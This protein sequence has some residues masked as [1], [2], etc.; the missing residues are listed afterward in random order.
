MLLT[1]EQILQGV[2][3][4]NNQF[5]QRM[6]ALKSKGMS[7]DNIQDVVMKAIESLDDSHRSFVIYGD[8][9]SGKTEMMIGLNA[10]LLDLGY[11]MI[12]NLVNDSKDMLAQNLDRFTA[13]RLNPAP[14]THQ[15]VGEIALGRPYVI[16][17]KKNAKNLHTLNSLVSK[18]KGEGLV[19]ID[20]EADHA[21]PNAKVNATDDEERSK[22]N[23]LVHT[24]LRR[25]RTG[26]VPG[27]YIGVTATPARLD[28]NATFGNE[29]ERW[30]YYKPHSGYVGQDFFFPQSIQGKM[31]VAYGLNTFPQNTGNDKEQLC[32][33][34]L[35]FLC[36]V[37]DIN[38]AGGEECNFSM[39][40]HTSRKTKEQEEDEKVLNGIL[41]R[42]S[43][44]Q[45]AKGKALFG[46]LL[47]MARARMPNDEERAQKI[48]RYI[49]GNIARNKVGVINSTTQ[50]EG[51]AGILKPV[52]PFTFAIGGNIVSRGLTFEHLLSMYFTR[53]VKANFQ[54][55]TYIQRARMFGARDK[56]L[57]RHFELWIPTELFR[58]W[59]RCFSYHKLSVEAIKE[60]RGA[61]VWIAGEGVVPTQM[62]AIN[63]AAVNMKGGE[64]SFGLFEFQSEHEQ[65]MTD[66]NAGQ[67]AVMIDKL[68]QAL[69]EECFPN[70]VCAYI[71]SRI[72]AG[73]SVYFH[74]HTVFAVKPG[75][76]YTQEE[77]EKCS[78]KERFFRRESSEQAFRNTPL[79]N[80]RQ[81]H[82]R[83]QGAFVLQVAEWSGEVYQSDR[84]NQTW[85]SPIRNFSSE[86]CSGGLSAM[87]GSL[88]S[89][90][91]RQSIPMW[92]SST[93]IHCILKSQRKEK[94]RG[95]SLSP[96]KVWSASP[97]CERTAA[98][99]SSL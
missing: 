49:A 77:I 81:P 54:Q 11:S 1:A 43:D 20:D 95:N 30:I 98:N 74:R 39:L 33:A 61:P 50:A 86:P 31:E 32:K 58:D 69:G 72:D 59:H 92:C 23:S 28:L 9:Q 17:S 75:H 12:I 78:A 67:P 40:I 10:K 15:S 22:I 76:G 7:V 56:R 94:A 27:A 64:M 87:S 96:P 85:R 35:S 93:S 48:L 47:I 21:T 73:E 19:V 79:A 90:K 82:A 5:E 46:R 13:A 29:S 44:P 34:V 63:R 97:C 66:G 53:T 24:L 16:L 18:V 37:A 99:A 36:N 89:S 71:K 51:R 83:A 55:D 45:S 26:S 42:L 70:H 60:G 65:L 6:S 91:W 2:E 4:P 14:K 25:D 88:L 80:I 52:A 38:S 62:S 8:P 84:V 68:Y 3:S 57:L 41:S